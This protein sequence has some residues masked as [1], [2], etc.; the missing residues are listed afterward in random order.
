MK[1]LLKVKETSPIRTPLY[2]RSPN[3][4]LTYILTSETINK[5]TFFCPYGVS[6]R[7][8]PLNT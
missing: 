1:P 2:F 3:A 5:D 7:E 4:V 6:I 8:V